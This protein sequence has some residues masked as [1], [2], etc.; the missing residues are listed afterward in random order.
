[1]KDQVEMGYYMKR[2]ETFLQLKMYD[3]CIADC[4]AARILFPSDLNIYLTSA[5]A[6]SDNGQLNEA[7][8]MIETAKKIDSKS[9]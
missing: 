6:M 3:E 9:T 4:D 1:M 5:T 2:A 7:L 8:K